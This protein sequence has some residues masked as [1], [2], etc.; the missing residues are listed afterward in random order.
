MWA[1][2]RSQKGEFLFLSAAISF[3]VGLALARPAVFSLP[4]SAVARPSEIAPRFLD[5]WQSCFDAQRILATISL[6]GV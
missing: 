2:L 6:R 5:A 3:A 1:P 4:T